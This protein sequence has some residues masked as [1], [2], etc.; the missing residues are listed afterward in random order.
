[1]SERHNVMPTGN[2]DT[3]IFTH[4]NISG[5]ARVHM[6]NVFNFGGPTST[7]QGVLEWLK[8]IDPSSSHNQA[9]IQFQE[10]TLNWFFEDTTFQSWRDR[11]TISSPQLLWCR[12]G[13]GAGKTT[14]VSQVLTHLHGRGVLRENLAVAYCRQAEQSVQTAA[15]LLISLLMQLY[16]HEQGLRI[17]PTVEAAYKSLPY[18][19]KERPSEREL[20]HWLNL[21]VEAEGPIFVLLDALDEMKPL[22]KQKLLRLLQ[23]TPHLKLLVTSRYAPDA[24]S[25]FPDIQELE[26]VS[27]ERDIAT[28]VN[29]RLVEEGTEKFRRL[30]SQAPGR[31]THANIQQEISWK[32]VASAN[33]MYV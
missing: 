25:G 20:Q 33:S 31:G 2:Q 6:G 14:L 17:P 29:A 19:R 28:L 16:Q 24:E 5:H 1:M 9:C 30:I 32:V 10:G 27:H 18:F 21:K 15:N 7:V 13:I 23:S 3:Q 22:F 26:F 12:G 4:T 11:R 8:P